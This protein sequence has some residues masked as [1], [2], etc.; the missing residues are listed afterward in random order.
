LLVLAKFN[1]FAID[2]KKGATLKPVQDWATPYLLTYKLDAKMQEKTNKTAKIANVSYLNSLFVKCQ[3]KHQTTKGEYL[4]L[5]RTQNAILLNYSPEEVMDCCMDVLCADFENFNTTNLQT[6]LLEMSVADV[7][8]IKNASAALLYYDAME[9]DLATESISGA[10]K[11]FKDYLKR[12]TFLLA[13]LILGTTSVFAQGEG[14]VCKCGQKA[15]FLEQVEMF[16]N[17]SGLSP[18]TIL[19]LFENQINK[20]WHYNFH[21]RTNDLNAII[22][23]DVI[24]PFSFQ[25]S[26]LKVIAD[27]RNYI[28]EENTV[29]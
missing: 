25:G 15:S 21:F 26:I 4:T 1:R 27:K 18:F 24:V 8:K 14:N 20:D 10:I 17:E 23:G 22:K 5:I 7:L 28:R 11:M 6:A 2:K 16:K 12:V 9:E 13:F 19:V 29:K 3:S